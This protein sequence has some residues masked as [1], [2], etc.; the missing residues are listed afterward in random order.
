MDLLHEL[1]AV[2]RL[3]TLSTEPEGTHLTREYLVRRAA[4]LDRLADHPQHPERAIDHIADADIYA[5][6]LLAHDITHN[7]TQ[8]PIPAG[9]PCWTDNPRN[10][11]RQ[12]HRAWITHHDL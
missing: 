7:T 6:E 12:E 3:H 4:A 1:H 8:G 11:A 5:R 9:A 2:Q 10:Y